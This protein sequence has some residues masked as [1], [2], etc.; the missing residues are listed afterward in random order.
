MTGIVLAPEVA[1]LNQNPEVEPHNALVNGMM[2]STSVTSS[3]LVNVTVATVALAHV[4]QTVSLLQVAQLLMLWQVETQAVPPS[5]L[6]P[7][8]QK[9]HLPAS[10][11]EAQFSGQQIPAEPPVTMVASAAQHV[12]VEVPVAFS[13]KALPM[14]QVKQLV[15]PPA[16]PQVLHSELHAE[17]VEMGLLVSGF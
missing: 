10:E 8:L 2:L 3:A 13:E 14:A 17:H 7:G 11:H 4:K 12:E 5:N 15:D 9:S 6:Y 16:P 1:A